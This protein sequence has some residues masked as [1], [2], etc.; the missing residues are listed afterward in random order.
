[1]KN[2]FFYA[3]GSSG[4]HGCEAL[5]RS[6]YKIYSEQ[7]NCSFSSFNL[8][9]DLVYLKNTAIKL[10]SINSK[11]N[12]FSFSYFLYLLK[13]KINTSDY[14][15]FR[16]LFSN[17]IS[18]VKRDEFY[19]SIGGDNYSYGASEWLYYLNKEINKK[20][21][22]TIL[23]GCSIL[24]FIKDNSLINDLAIYRKII[25]RESMTYRALQELNLKNELYLLPDPAF[26]LNRID[27]PLPEYFIEGNTVG[28]NVSPMI[29]GY[30]KNKGMTL[31][32]YTKLIEFIIKETDM[33][34]ALIPHVVWSHNDDRA[35]LRLLYEQFKDTRRVCLIEDHNAEELKGYIARCRFMIAART[36]ASIAAYS[37]CVP[38]LVVGYSVK[39]RGIAKD[40]F[41]T[42]ENYVIPVQSLV[43]QNDL[44][45][46]FLYLLKNEKK[47][48]SRM[49]ILIPEYNEQVWKIKD[50]IIK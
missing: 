8:E 49:D 30:E 43:N 2:L 31:Q 7:F 4:N 45:S 14:N 1:M 47:I 35:P 48:K 28:I 34:V 23:L 17:F 44:K 32:N 29:I 27:L 9:E 41:G 38:T 15:Y 40:L 26:Q 5:T 10:Q 42:E 24:D 3:N 18:N 21:G 12:K 22:E 36:H 37:Q 13:Q 46:A 19:C 50:I 6:L 20:G 39:A 16:L 25:C 33:Q 11:I